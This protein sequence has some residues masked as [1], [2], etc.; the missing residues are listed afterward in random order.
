MVALTGR[1]TCADAGQMMTALSASQ[2]S[3][4]KLSSLS[5]FDYIK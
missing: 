4:S 3:F 5:L 1:L 2:A